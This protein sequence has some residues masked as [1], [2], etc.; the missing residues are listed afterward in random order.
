MTSPEKKL[1]E[2]IQPHPVASNDPRDWVDL[3]GNYLFRYAL[4]RVRERTAAE[5]LV[6]ETLLAA[7]QALDRHDGESSE[8]GWL[9]GILR[10]KILDYFRRL[11]REQALF[12]EVSLPE[13]LEGRFDESGYWKREPPL[14]PAD[15][16]ANAASLM[17][18]KE[19][20]VVLKQCLNKLPSRHAQAFVLREMEKLEAG[21]IRDVLGITPANLWVLLHRAR[22]QLR[23]CLEK[24]W[25]N[26]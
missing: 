1:P 4:L 6:Q 10:H 19:F 24:K 21:K 3:H 9:T 7:L 20:M 22:M 15:W 2:E 26:L 13:E 23:L 18:R 17:E 12:Y 25:L 14:G 11:S 5:D 8:R 16:G